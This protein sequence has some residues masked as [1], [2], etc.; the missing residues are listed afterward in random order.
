[1]TERAEIIFPAP[2]GDWG[3]PIAFFVGGYVMRP[4]KIKKGKSRR[5]LIRIFAVFY[6]ENKN[7]CTLGQKPLVWL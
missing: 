5:R 4:I 7:F 1:M 3:K 2:S 6:G